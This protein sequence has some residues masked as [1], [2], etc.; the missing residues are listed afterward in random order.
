METAFQAH[1][2]RE[3]INFALQEVADLA[4]AKAPVRTGALRDSINWV[5][6][7]DYSGEASVGVPYAAAQEN[8]FTT[9]NGARVAGKH[10]FAPAAMA[11]QKL[12]VAELNKYIAANT[13]GKLTAP[14]HGTQGGG[15]GGTAHKYLRRESTGAGTRYVYGPKRYTT[16]K[17]KFQGKPGGRK[18]PTTKFQARKPG[19]RR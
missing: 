9:P 14:P 7:S 6:L 17:R 12:L 13:Q 19:K 10:Y 3:I 16:T 18:Q 8:G 5:M 11:G 2:I 4:R 1:E 15:G